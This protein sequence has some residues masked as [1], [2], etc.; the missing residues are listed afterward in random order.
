[1]SATGRRATIKDVA[2]RAGVSR[3]TV[4]AALNGK[5]NLNAGTVARV[6]EVAAELGYE[7][8]ALARGLRQSRLG[9]IALVIRPLDDVDTR[10]LEGVDYFLRFAGAAAL[11]ALEH[12]Y[13]LLLVSDPTRGDAPSSSLAADGYI[14][15]T[16]LDGDILVDLLRR[17]GTPFVAVGVAPERTPPFPAVTHD[18][19]SDTEL[20]LSHLADCGARRITL[21]TG[22]DRN[23]WNAV[24]AASY[25]AWTKQHDFPVDVVALNEATGVIGGHEAGLTLLESDARPDAVYCLT[26][27]HA[28]GLAQAAQERGL[29]VPRDLQI[30]AGSDAEVCRTFN[31]TISALNLHPEAS[32]RLAADLL[33][34]LLTDH[35]P[36]WPVAGPPNTLEVRGSSRVRT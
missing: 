23:D 30:V 2:A 29:N 21:I 31:P 20:V 32:A 10:T 4:S 36:S 25:R 19:A 18:V 5:G 17:R 9:V 8:N 11:S 6:R 12:G 15:D 27:H 35:P 22:T 3:T 13:A 1:M 7:P 28:A 16:P 14:V 26:A 24:A 34:G 33:V